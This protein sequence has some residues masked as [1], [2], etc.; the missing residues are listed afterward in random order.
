MEHIPNDITVSAEEISKIAEQSG[1]YKLHPNGA[2][3]MRTKN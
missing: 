2:V 3:L 1:K